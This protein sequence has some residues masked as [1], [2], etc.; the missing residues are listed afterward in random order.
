MSQNQNWNSHFEN[1]RVV[2]HFFPHNEQYR[3]CFRR[4]HLRDVTA[5]LRIP[6]RAWDVTAQR[7]SERAKS[8]IIRVTAYFKVIITISALDQILIKRSVKAGDTGGTCST[9]GGGE[10]C[11]QNFSRKTLKEETTWWIWWEDNNKM[12]K[13]VKLFLPW[14]RM[15]ESTSAL[16]GG[17]WSASRP[18]CFNRR[19]MNPLIP[20]R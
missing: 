2:K 6:R 7:A 13:R 14:R 11:I 5:C 18:G 19:G 10:K 1:R 8:V 20:I 16:D 3:H 17:V 9:Y 15:R 4:V 12:G